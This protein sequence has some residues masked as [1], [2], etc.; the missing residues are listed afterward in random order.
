MKYLK[1]YQNFS[2]KFDISDSDE[3]D[4]KMSKEKMN[5]MQDYITEFSQKKA[6]IEQIFKD[7]KKD[8]KTIEKELENLLGKQDVS[9][10]ADRNPFLVDF[11]EISKMKKEVEDLQNKRAEDKIKID[12][13]NQQ[14]ALSTSD[15]VKKNLKFTITDVQNRLADKSKRISEI[16]KELVDKKKKLDDRIISQK[17]EI[18]EFIQKINTQE[19]KK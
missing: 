8:S 12:D 1:N 18:D 4:V 16:E 17:K 14:I 6:Q 15:D 11:V 9:A 5:K 2:E 19:S 13:F 7:T 10:G 3:P